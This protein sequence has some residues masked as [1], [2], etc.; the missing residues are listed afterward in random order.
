MLEVGN[1]NHNF[2]LPTLTE[3]EQ[4]AH[5]SL[6]AAAKSPLVLGNDPRNM[7]NATLAILGN[8]EVIAVNQVNSRT[9][10]IHT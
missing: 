3:T 7:S 9:F 10:R 8:A 4:R 2:N 1:T 6:W 5:F